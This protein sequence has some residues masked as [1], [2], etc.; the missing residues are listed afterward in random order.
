MASPGLGSSTYRRSYNSFSGV[1]A[2]ATFAGKVIGEV[3]GMI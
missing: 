2:H 1:D 3:Q